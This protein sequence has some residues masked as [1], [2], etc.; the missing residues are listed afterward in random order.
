MFMEPLCLIT[1]LE[2]NADTSFQITSVSF[3]W[4]EGDTQF[5]HLLYGYTCF[6]GNVTMFFFFFQKASLKLIAT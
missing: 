5:L 2:T 1:F 3:L 4:W 6:A